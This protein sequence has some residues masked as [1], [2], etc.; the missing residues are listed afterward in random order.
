MSDNVKKVI[1]NLTKQL[2]SARSAKDRLTQQVSALSD[3]VV[4]LEGALAGLNLVLEEDAK[5]SAPKAEV[6]ES[7]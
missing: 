1:E 3:Q 5:E 2:E 7:V 4:R 6:E